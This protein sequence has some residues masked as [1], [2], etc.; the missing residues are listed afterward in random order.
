MNVGDFLA[1]LDIESV[2][3]VVFYNTWLSGY[4]TFLKANFKAMWFT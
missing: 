3:K 1:L 4:R 2:G